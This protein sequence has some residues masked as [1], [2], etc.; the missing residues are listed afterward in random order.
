MRVYVQPR[1]SHGSR[2]SNM[3][4]DMKAEI[5]ERLTKWLQ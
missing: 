2:I 5:I 4:E 3:P 1:G